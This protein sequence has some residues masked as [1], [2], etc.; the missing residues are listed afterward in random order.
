MGLR[1]KR[2][3][4]FPEENKPIDFRELVGTD[5]WSR[6]PRQAS[7]DAVEEVTGELPGDF[8][9]FVRLYGDGLVTG[10]LCI[11]HPEGIDPLID[12]IGRG[13]RKL[14][15]LLSDYADR[16]ESLSCD[17]A[18]LIPFGY[19]DWDGDDCF[20]VPREGREFDVLLVFRQWATA[21]LYEGGFTRFIGGVL[22]GRAVP[23]GW[24]VLEPRWAPLEGTPLR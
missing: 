3:G 1:V 4:S 24:P 11:P 17:P 13:R 5:P 16:L 9:E 7:W 22:T 12:F 6:E 18:V 21:E 15:I 2:R 10:H 19:S 8:K 23:P 14:E 20:L